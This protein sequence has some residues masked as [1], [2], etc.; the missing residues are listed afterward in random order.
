MGPDTVKLPTEVS[1]GPRLDQER[2][3]EHNI[4]SRARSGA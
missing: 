3:G 4:S 1:E 2:V